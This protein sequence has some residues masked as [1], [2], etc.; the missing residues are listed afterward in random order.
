MVLYGVTGHRLHKLFKFFEVIKMKFD[1]GTTIAANYVMMV[2]LTL[3]N[4]F[5][6]HYSIFKNDLSEKPYIGE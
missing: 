3:F 2:V 5:I 4:E 6:P 1:D